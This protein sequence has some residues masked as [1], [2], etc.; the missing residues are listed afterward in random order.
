LLLENQIGQFHP[1]LELNIKIIAVMRWIK[2]VL[3][4]IFP[5]NVDRNG[6]KTVKIDNLPKLATGGVAH[7]RLKLLINPAGIRVDGQF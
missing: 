3:C 1:I 4:K 6:F 7:L 2:G 5:G